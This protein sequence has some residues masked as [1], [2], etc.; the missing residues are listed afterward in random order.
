MLLLFTEN[1]ALLMKPFKF[2]FI[3]LLRLDFLFKFL[4]GVQL[5][6]LGLS[7]T[8]L[9][10]LDA[11]KLWRDSLLE[12][13]LKLVVK[14]SIV[15]FNGFGLAVVLLLLVICEIHFRRAIILDKDIVGSGLL[16]SL[17]LVVFF[18]DPV[19]V[20]HCWK[21]L[22]F[23]IDGLEEDTC[24]KADDTDQCC[25]HEHPDKD[26]HCVDH[27]LLVLNLSRVS[28]AL[29]VLVT[30]LVTQLNYVEKAQGQCPHEAKDQEETWRGAVTLT[31]S[32]KVWLSLLE[33]V[34]NEVENAEC[35]F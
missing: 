15:S 4:L 12:V 30:I 5:G 11:L 17:Q 20:L 7:C 31:Y 22:A 25:D 32:C 33:T 13:I 26:L 28:L 19:S 35:N 1:G 24:D 8:L 34:E 23:V 2:L 14:T 6:L 27:G 21:L 3:L 29:E 18:R 16:V 9:G 10:L